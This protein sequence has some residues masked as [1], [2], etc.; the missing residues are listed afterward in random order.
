MIILP[1]LISARASSTVHVGML[2]LLIGNL[3]S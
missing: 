3:A 2:L 1:F